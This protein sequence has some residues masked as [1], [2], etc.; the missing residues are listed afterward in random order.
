MTYEEVQDGVRSLLGSLT[1]AGPHQ[2]LTKS[3]LS[4]RMGVSPAVVSDIC[5]G[6]RNISLRNLVRACGALGVPLS[7]VIS[8]VEDD[9]LDEYERE[10]MEQ[11]AAIR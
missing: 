6:R 10:E 3:A 1:A 4:R 11:E 9:L 5:N 7:H 8:D 2:V